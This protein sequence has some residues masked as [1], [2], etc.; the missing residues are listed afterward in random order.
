MDNNNNVKTYHCGVDVTISTWV[1]VESESEA[2][3]EVIAK[4]VAKERVNSS[5]PC[6]H[7]E[8]HHIGEV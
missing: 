4:E 6:T 2:E 8:V 5:E 3:A 1:H 7:V